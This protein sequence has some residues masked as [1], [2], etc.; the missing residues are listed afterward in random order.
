LLGTVARRGGAEKKDR[1]SLVWDYIEAILHKR[2]LGGGLF[3]G[4]D[5]TARRENRRGMRS[6]ADSG[7]VGK[8][9][10]QFLKGGEGKKAH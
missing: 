1:V 8:L 5:V 9:R 6:N 7:R 3:R 10:L 2:M 4:G